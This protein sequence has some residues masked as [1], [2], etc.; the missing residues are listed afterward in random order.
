M[1][2]WIYLL[3]GLAAGL[4]VGLYLDRLLRGK[5]YQSRDEII[6]QAQQEAGN[7]RK[8]QELAGKEELLKRREQQEKEIQQ[9]RDKLRDKEADVAAREATLKERAADFSKRERMVESTQKKLAERAK[10]VETQE[11]ELE[12]ILND[13][14]EQLY[15]IS[16][17]SQDAA[18]DMLMDRLN[19]QL[20]DETG[21]LILKYQNELKQDS[22]RLAREIVGMAVQRCAAAH[23]SET[24]VSTV[25]IPNDEMKGRIIGREG[26]NIRAFEKATG[27]DVIVD[28][29]PGVVVVSAFDNVRREI[30]KL[31]LEKVDSGRPDSSHAHRRN[32]RRNAKEMDAHIRQLGLE[33]CSGGERRRPAREAHRPDGTAQL[34][35]SA[36]SQNVRRHS[37]EVATLTGMMAEQLGLDGRSPGA[38]DF[39]TTSAKQP[40]TRWKEG[41]PP[42]APSCS[43][44]T[45]KDRKSCTPPPGITTTF[46]SI[47]S[48]PCWSPPPTPF[49]PLARRSPR[50][51]RKVR[52]PAGRTRIAGLRL[53]RRRTIVYAVQAGREIR[54]IVDATEVNDREAAKM[55]RDIAEGN[56]KIADL[57]RRG[58]SHRAAGIAGD[59]VRAVAGR[60]AHK[61]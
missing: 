8:E 50:D 39:C 29:T 45:A 46:A 1:P 26:R 9:G 7:A 12:R 38:A 6:R 14:R 32:R 25:D 57:P 2:D 37:I 40:T 34:P 36:T 5:A 53:S 48:T 16:G 28:D 31:S 58:Q 44:A 4:G 15:K 20:K 47:T 21:G 51:A 33:A 42:S 56:R 22:E 35:Q 13:E 11:A 24:T 52:S 43:S 30:A 41:I 27:V 3:I 18:K 60:P 54:V 59:G 61:S 23:T 19:R 17:L 49:P 55:C 10:V